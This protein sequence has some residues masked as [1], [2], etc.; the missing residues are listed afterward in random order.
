MD[1]KFLVSLML[2]KLS[3]IILGKED[4]VR[5]LLISIVEIIKNLL[6]NGANLIR[7]RTLQIRQTRVDL[8]LA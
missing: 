6:R 1:K 3:R 5:L 7:K 2:T 8:L 4:K